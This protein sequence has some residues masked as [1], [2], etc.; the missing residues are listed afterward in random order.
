[1]DK[2]IR[3]AITEFLNFSINNENSDYMI[4]QSLLNQPQEYPLLTKVFDILV[5][6]KDFLFDKQK[7]FG[8]KKVFDRA[9]Q[10]IYRYTGFFLDETKYYQ[11]TYLDT[12][13][14]KS[15]P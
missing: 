12:N 13:K 1:M 8:N 2:K 3:G 9:N 7:I 14:E 4:K 6:Y 15:N 10:I 5:K 11:T